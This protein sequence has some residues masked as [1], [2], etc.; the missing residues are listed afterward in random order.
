MPENDG[1]WSRM[2]QSLKQAMA[3]RQRPVPRSSV[4]QLVN[5]LV[6]YFALWGLMI[7]SLDISYWLTLALALPAAGFLARIFIIFHDCAHGSFLH[8]RRGNQMLEFF[9]GVLTFTPYRQWRHTHAR[10][11]ATSGDL[12]RRGT[13]DIWT[14]TVEEYL[15]ASSWTRLAYRITRSPFVLFVIAPLYLFLVHY[16]FPS[17][18]VGPRERRGVHWTNAALL[19]IVAVMSL[20]IGIKGYLLIQLPVFMISGMAGVWL[21]YVQHQFEGVYWQRGPD[22]DFTEAALRGSSFYKLPRVLQWFSGNIGYHHI[23]HLSPGIPNYS[24]EKCHREI[25]LF[26]QIKP[27]TLWSS[28]RSLSFRLWD[29]RSNRLVGFGPVRAIRRE[30]SLIA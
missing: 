28:F 16:R 10:H 25:P 1:T 7:W 6:P 4:W 8:S 20:T 13:G 17:S 27:V 23:H 2:T 26:Q 30:R 15:N 5:T 14:L 9:L 24:L 12:D 21:F 22:W 19:A 18:S 11:H 3:H 29:E